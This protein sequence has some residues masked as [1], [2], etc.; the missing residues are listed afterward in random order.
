MPGRNSLVCILLLL[1]LL[2]AVMASSAAVLELKTG[3]KVE[4]DY[5]G[6]SPTEI[7]FKVGNQMLVFPVADASMIQFASPTA[8]A[9]F[10]KD[11]VKALKILKSL[12]SVTRAGVDFS[13]INWREYSRWVTDATVDIDA[14]LEQHRLAG[15][16]GIQDEA[17]KAMR[18]YNLAAQVW[19][20][21]AIEVTDEIMQECPMVREGLSSPLSDGSRLLQ[22]RSIKA[23]WSCAS[24][25]ISRL[26]KLVKAK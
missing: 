4:G 13:G 10:T 18:F 9:D 11:S 5:L 20:G 1:G 23:L 22:S 21:P 14:F 25:R 15:N 8:E 24:D 19:H 12:Q 3:Q 6:G 16:Q 26:E 2:Y 7:K 17:Q